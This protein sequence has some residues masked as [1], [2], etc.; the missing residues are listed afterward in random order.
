[1]DLGL[2]LGNLRPLG[3]PPPRLCFVDLTSEAFGLPASTSGGRPQFGLAQLGALY[4]EVQCAQRVL[5][6]FVFRPRSARCLL[7]VGH[8]WRHLRV[9]RGAGTARHSAG[10]LRRALVL[11][12]HEA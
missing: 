10:G 3:L 4:S 12:L 8:V 6:K 9:L 7:P 5:D 2:F 11:A 1:M